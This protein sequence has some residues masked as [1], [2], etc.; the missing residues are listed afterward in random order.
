MAAI[1]VQ[2]VSKLWGS[3]KAVDDVSFEVPVGKLVVLLGPSGSG[4]RSVRDRD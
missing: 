1:S 2:R 4:P 3:I